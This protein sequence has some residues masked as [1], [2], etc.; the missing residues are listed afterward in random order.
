MK[1]HALLIGINRYQDAGNSRLLYA[2]K[3]VVSLEFFLRDRCG[4][5][6]TSLVNDQATP[7][8]VTE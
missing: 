8:A 2:E 4:F 6:V 7:S 1:K 5:A 3:D